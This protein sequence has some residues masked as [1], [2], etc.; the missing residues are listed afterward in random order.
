MGEDRAPDDRRRGSDG[1]RVLRIRVSAG[2]IYEMGGPA[3][4]ENRSSGGLSTTFAAS[5]VR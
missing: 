4:L 5:R 1:S 3:A 2:T